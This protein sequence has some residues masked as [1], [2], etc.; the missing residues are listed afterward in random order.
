[1][2]MARWPTFP[3]AACTG[4]R[5]KPEALCV[6]IAV[7]HIGIVTD[8]AVKRAGEWIAELPTSLTDKQNEIAVR[9][10]K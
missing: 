7:H 9:V 4:F 5:L 6:K 3:C 2:P 8:M 10:L 1:M